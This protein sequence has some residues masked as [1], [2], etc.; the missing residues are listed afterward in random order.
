[1]QAA[2]RG[3]SRDERCLRGDS[4]CFVWVCV[5]MVHFRMKGIRDSRLLVRVCVSVLRRRRVCGSRSSG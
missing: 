3:Q 1:M 2:D 5:S 4:S